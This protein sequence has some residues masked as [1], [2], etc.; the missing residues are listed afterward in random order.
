MKTNLISTLIKSLVFLNTYLS[1]LAQVQVTMTIPNLG[2]PYLSDYVGN[3]RNQVL[4]LTNN[5]PN[6]QIIRLEGLIQQLDAPGYFLRTKQNYRP[7][8]PINLGPF[9]TKTFFANQ[10][11]F[12]FLNESNLESNVPANIQRQIQLTG[13]LPEGQYQICVR[14]FDFRTNQPLSE[15]APVGCQFFNV[16]LGT[17]PQLI[18]PICEDTINDLFPNFVWTPAISLTPL[19]NLEYTLYIVEYRSRAL[20]PQ[21]IMEQSIQFRGANPIVISNIRSNSYMYS[22]TDFPL[23]R[24]S[25]YIVCVVASDRQNSAM[26]ENQGRSEICLFHIREDQQTSGNLGG[27]S[28]GPKGPFLKDKPPIAMATTKISGKLHHRFRYNQFDHVQVVQQ[29]SGQDENKLLLSLSPYIGKNLVSKFFN[30]SGAEPG[31]G[32]GSGGGSTGQLPSIQSGSKGIFQTISE[33]SGWNFF[34]FPIFADVESFKDGTTLFSDNPYN[35]GSK[36]LANV[37]VSLVEQYILVKKGLS[38]KIEDFVVLSDWWT[39]FN[40][41][42]EGISSLKERKIA[43]TKTDASGNYTFNAALINPCGV[44]AGGKPGDNIKVYSPYSKLDGVYTAQD[45]GQAIIR[46]LR[47]IVE[48]DRYYSPN[49]MIVALP[50]KEMNLGVQTALVKSYGVKIRVLGLDG[51]KKDQPLA[52]NVFV[53]RRTNEIAGLHPGHPVDEPVSTSNLKINLPG[54]F[55]KHTMTA[56]YATASDHDGYL[57]IRNMIAHRTISTELYY[58]VLKIPVNDPY[59]YKDQCIPFAHIPNSLQTGQQSFYASPQNIFS[60]YSNKR[61]NYQF[62]EPVFEQEVKMKADFPRIYFQAMEE[63]TVYHGETDPGFKPTAPLPNA[64]VTIKYNHPGWNNTYGLTDKNGKFI[65]QYQSMHGQPDGFF[66]HIEV[67][68]KGYFSGYR[69]GIIVSPNHGFHKLRLGE[70]Y[71]TGEIS[72]SPKGRVKLEVEDEL[73]MAVKSHVRFGDGLIVETKEKDC[74]F[75]PGKPSDP[76]A[77]DPFFQVIPALGFSISNI[78]PETDLK[79]KRNFNILPEVDPMSSLRVAMDSLQLKQ[80]S[81]PNLKLGSL[82]VETLKKQCKQ[83]IDML[84]PSG[85]DIPLSVKPLSTQYEILDTVVSVKEPRLGLIRRTTDLGALVVKFRRKKAIIRVS[86]GPTI[87]IQDGM[88]KTLDFVPQCPNDT[89]IVRLHTYQ[90]GFIGLPG[91]AHFHFQNQGDKFKLK[92]D[93]GDR[94][95]PIEEWIHLPGFEEKTF[96]F[97]LEKAQKIYGSVIDIDTKEPIDK[98][99]VFAVIGSNEFGHHY[100]ETFTDSDGKFELGKIPLDVFTITAS[101]T[102]KNVTY[103]GKTVTFL[104]NQSVIVIELKKLEGWDISSLFGYPVSVTK[105]EPAGEDN[106]SVSGMVTGLPGNANFKKDPGDPVRIPFSN[107]EI[108]KSASPLPDGRHR[109]VVVSEKMPLDV[110]KY[111]ARLKKTFFAFL[112]GVNH[113]PSGSQG[114]FWLNGNQ[115]LTIFRDS[116]FSGSIYAMPEVTLSSFNFSNDFQGRF[117]LSEDGQDARV[118]A[119]VSQDPLSNVSF[120]PGDMTYYVGTRQASFQF[121]GIQFNNSAK[122]VDP[123]FKVEGFSAFS[124]RLE[125]RLEK[126]TFRLV[127]KIRFGIPDM[128]PSQIEL[129][130]G[131][132]V[133]TSQTLAMK[134][135]SSNLEFKL[136]TWTV[137]ANSW[138]FEQSASAIKLNNPSI[139]TPS[140]TVKIADLLIQDKKP[141]LGLSNVTITSGNPKL[142]GVA[143]LIFGSGAGLQLSYGNWVHMEDGQKK[144]YRIMVHKTGGGVVCHA[145]LS[146]FLDGGNL[147]F[148]EFQIFSD[149]HEALKLHNNSIQFYEIFPVA[150]PQIR[151]YTNYF[152]IFGSTS[153][154]LPL[155]KA[156]MEMVALRFTKPSNQLQMTLVVNGLRIRNM[157]GHVEFLAD[158][159][160]AATRT[161][162]LRRYEAIGNIIVRT[163]Q[164]NHIMTLRGRLIH[165]REGGNFIS[166]IETFHVK[167]DVDLMPGSQKQKIW[168][169]GPANNDAGHLQL[170]EGHILAASGLWQNLKYY[171]AFAGADANKGFKSDK[172]KLWYTVLGDIKVDDGQS[173]D[174]NEVNVTYNNS[175]GVTFTL[176]FDFPT[177]TLIGTLN[178]T[179]PP[180]GLEMGAATVY[181][182]VN[183]GFKFSPNGFYIYCQVSQ[184]QIRPVPGT[185]SMFLLI[186]ATPVSNIDIQH[187]NLLFASGGPTATWKKFNNFPSCLQRI[188]GI[189]MAASYSLVDFEVDIDLVVVGIEVAVRVFADMYTFLNFGSNN[190]NIGF[191]VAAHASVRV[192]ARVLFCTFCAAAALD[193]GLAGI[194][195]LQSGS[196]ISGFGQATIS[197]SICSLINFKESIRVGVVLHSQSGLSVKFGS[198]GPQGACIPTMANTGLKCGS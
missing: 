177:K 122:L 53:G 124:D 134:Y 105:I 121:Q 136:G 21:Q 52:V 96:H 32:S 123:T 35:N 180:S 54:I 57:Y 95:V 193:V 64:Q 69:P 108:R 162:T 151:T 195:S 83:A 102:D 128:I 29:E 11:D 16:T 23:R 114:N 146:P 145:N 140:L 190:T 129:A 196:N 117:Y 153:L 55:A 132:I 63:N 116:D 13:L 9:E 159:A 187:R 4:I 141:P 138:Q 161:L 45:E 51:V 194:L 167:S 39:M 110:D 82:S 88:G 17:P 71:P 120:A 60:H 66:V 184:A 101:K 22:P 188:D 24:G 19:R 147:G 3:A 175:G 58:M 182:P 192:S 158:D 131:S 73:G 165:R 133:V 59:N 28:L 186:G 7:N 106:L 90:Q 92:I 142:A 152:E 86:C 6:P 1:S 78:E 172:N 149:G 126:D 144:I 154:N 47:L 98:A 174:F 14:A 125:S 67:S 148:S 27:P 84:A 97:T 139:I 109:A 107:I 46:V 171:A 33:G 37:N 103:I 99:H 49:V 189:F 81:N 118:R 44:V 68:K 50:G 170:E 181:G 40:G 113:K 156:D 89:A 135:S 15:E 191:G 42:P 56:L 198:N 20:N 197:G 72:L 38:G 100:I 61:F 5:S 43:T 176:K 80:A 104:P 25:T 143:D 36:P 65:L 155:P 79:L 127:S 163:P 166:R 183:S 8:N 169:A 31:G 10:S 164:N 34:N 48:D 74:T 41:L 178:F 130:V 173:P 157:P 91:E 76:G 62:V 77:I 168:L 70:K 137:R 111:Y 115:R 30:E 12:A 150:N 119:F 26:F 160:N 179:P 18:Q 93:A 87:K 185:F 2:S 112:M 75:G 94:Y 85:D